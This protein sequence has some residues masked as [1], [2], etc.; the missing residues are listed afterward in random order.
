MEFARQSDGALRTRD[1]IILPGRMLRGIGTRAQEANGWFKPTNSCP[2]FSN[3]LEHGVYD[4]LMVR[5][6]VTLAF[7][8]ASPPRRRTKT[9][10]R[11]KTTS[12]LVDLA[13]VTQCL[14]RRI[15]LGLG[16]ED[17]AC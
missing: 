17:Q 3:T 4:D 12:P 11:Q 10:Q 14:H 5:L 13:L 6:I 8:D 15:V 1:F 2:T 9:E 7:L 16:S